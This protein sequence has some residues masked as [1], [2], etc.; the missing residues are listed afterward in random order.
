MAASGSSGIPC[1][2]TFIASSRRSLTR[3]FS[4]YSANISA[5][6]LVGASGVV[7]VVVA[8]FESE[9][10]SRGRERAKNEREKL[11][12]I[13]LEAALALSHQRSSKSVE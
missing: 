7:V 1:T 9:R 10:C 13:V 4:M 12:R 11:N 8:I 6:D 2:P 3:C 5:G